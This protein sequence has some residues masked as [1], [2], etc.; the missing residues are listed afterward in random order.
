MINIFDQRDLNILKNDF[1]EKLFSRQGYTKDYN[2]FLESLG[3]VSNSYRKLKNKSKGIFTITEKRRR[4]NE[5][6]CKNISLDTNKFLRNHNSSIINFKFQDLVYSRKI[7]KKYDQT[8]VTRKE[9][10]SEYEHTEVSLSQP[11]EII[12]ETKYITRDSIIAAGINFKYSKLKLGSTNISISS[13][14]SEWEQK[15]INRSKKRNDLTM[16]EKYLEK[17]KI[18]DAFFLNQSEINSNKMKL[19][20]LRNN[21]LIREKGLS[22]EII[23]TAVEDV[24]SINIFNLYRNKNYVKVEDIKNTKIK[25]FKVKGIAPV[26]YFVV[27]GIRYESLEEM[28]QTIMAK[29]KIL[30]AEEIIKKRHP[31]ITIN[32]EELIEKLKEHDCWCVNGINMRKKIFDNNKNY[33][34]TFTNVKTDFRGFLK[35]AKGKLKE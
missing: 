9:Q 23:K 3:A 33:W 16:R 25:R 35:A 13:I 11:D 34:N 31:K 5:F 10:Y 30:L 32:K 29:N 8:E 28:K 2:Y 20:R 24:K 12:N 21:K 17:R 22:T 7:T 6:I 14:I 15:L 18:L 4:L 1:T 19:Q 26:S 27:N